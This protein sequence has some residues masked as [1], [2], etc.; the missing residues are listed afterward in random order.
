MYFLMKSIAYHTMP[1]AKTLGA[2]DTLS[3]LGTLHFRHFRHF[4]LKQPIIPFE[5]QD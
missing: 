1:H 4:L 2:P 5:Q 3:T